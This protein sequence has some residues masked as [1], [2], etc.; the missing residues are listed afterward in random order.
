MNSSHPEPAPESSLSYEAMLRARGLGAPVLALEIAEGVRVEVFDGPE[1]LLTLTEQTADGHSAV[2]ARLP[3][4]GCPD[5]CLRFMAGT[6]SSPMPRVSVEP[7]AGVTIAVSDRK[8]LVAA[9][10]DSAP[11]IEIVVSH[12][13][14]ERT[15]HAYDNLG[16][17]Q[18]L[19]Y[20]ADADAD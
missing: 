3:Y 6:S 10:F 20:L 1:N 15:V 19:I 18:L 12:A 17:E 11:S 8:W 5:H 4:I 2:S 14:G 9:P 13:D 7:I 16:D